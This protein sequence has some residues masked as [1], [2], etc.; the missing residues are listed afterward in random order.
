MSTNT[1][2]LVVILQLYPGG[3]VRTRHS[4][5]LYCIYEISGEKNWSTNC[6]IHYVFML[7][8][9]RL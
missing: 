8:C 7:K 6:T 9:S 1:F 5:S 3:L 2:R 4:C